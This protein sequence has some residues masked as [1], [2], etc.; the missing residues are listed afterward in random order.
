LTGGGLVIDLGCGSGILSREVADAG[1][2]VLGIDISPAM[3]DLARRRVPY[4]DFRVGSVLT[5]DLPPCIAVAAVG[6]VINYAFDSGV[7]SVR[8]DRPPGL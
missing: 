4:G 3:I 6:E 5:G 8:L 1:Y 2:D 7:T